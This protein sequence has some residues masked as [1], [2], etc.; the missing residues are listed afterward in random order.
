MNGGGII[1]E[2]ILVILLASI[3]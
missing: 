3:L 2:C 1:R